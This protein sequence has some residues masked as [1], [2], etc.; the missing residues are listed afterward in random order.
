MEKGDPWLSLRIRQLAQN[1][2]PDLDFPLEPIT[3][4]RRRLLRAPRAAKRQP[5]RR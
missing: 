1:S 5:R 2:P 3:G 4:A